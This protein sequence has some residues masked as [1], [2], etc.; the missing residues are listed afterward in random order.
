MSAT[1]AD[2]G[3]S[4]VRRAMSAVTAHIREHDLRAGDTLP[5]ERHFADSLGVSRAVM[6][7][8]FGAL[9]ALNLIDVANGRKPKVAV[10]DESLIATSMT[11]GISTAQISVPDVWEVR[12]TIERRTAE[13]AAEH[14]T[15]EQAARIVELAKAI[16]RDVRDLG[17]VT[18]HDVEFHKAIADASHNLLFVQI[19]RAF[20]PLMENAVP[21]AWKTVPTRTQQRAIARRHLDVARAIAARDVAAAG[22]C[23]EQHFDSTIGA[24]LQSHEG[25]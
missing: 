25:A 20:G 10:I 12:R 1:A 24:L 5:G 4:L 22:E 13:L 15:D 19:V 3:E 17:A 16:A 18:K 8:A 7:E 14:R 21:E 9:A 23:M 2:A 11:H 6:R